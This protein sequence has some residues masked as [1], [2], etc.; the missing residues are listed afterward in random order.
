MSDEEQI[1]KALN[2]LALERR[3][4]ALLRNWIG[5]VLSVADFEI[6]EELQNLLSEKGG[7]HESSN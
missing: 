2:T 3:K 4:V 7:E 1:Q 5:N 6:D